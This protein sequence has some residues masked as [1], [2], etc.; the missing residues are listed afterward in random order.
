[1]FDIFAEISLGGGLHAIGAGA[2][3]NLIQIEFQDFILGILFFNLKCDDRFLHFAFPGS[4]LCQ[5]CILRQLLRDRATAFRYA[6]GRNVDPDSA[7]DRTGIDPGMLVK[8]IVFQRNES[9]L[10]IFRHLGQRNRQPVFHCVQNSDQ[11]SVDVK[12]LGRGSRT[13]I[14]AQI[15]GGLNG[16]R[17][18]TETDAD[19]DYKKR[20]NSNDNNGGDGTSGIIQNRFAGSC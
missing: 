13:D 5:K 10:Q 7:Q 1:M 14:A 9:I 11:F 15:G 18:E 12:Y 16:R 3:I 8:A 17:Q 4:L 2:E 6:A 20:H 19:S